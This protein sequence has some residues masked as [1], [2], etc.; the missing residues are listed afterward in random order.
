MGRP[1]ILS[2]VAPPVVQTPP[3]VVQA[4]VT[5]PSPTDG[6]R[7]IHEFT[8]VNLEQPNHYKVLAKCKCGFEGRCQ[9]VEEADVIKNR[10]HHAKLY[11]SVRPR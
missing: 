9:S 1:V 4:P 5:A 10:H 2:K 11:E 8:F 7:Q 3:A 6:V